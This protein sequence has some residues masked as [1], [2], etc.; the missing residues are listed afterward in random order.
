MNKFSY[1]F[2][3]YTVETGDTSVLETDV[4]IVF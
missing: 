3:N 2:V 1:K 4:S